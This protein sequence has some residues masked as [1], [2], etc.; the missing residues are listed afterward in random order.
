MSI[1]VGNGP[2]TKRRDSIIDAEAELLYMGLREALGGVAGV[3]G[4]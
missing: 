4:G 1:V 2:L 3:V